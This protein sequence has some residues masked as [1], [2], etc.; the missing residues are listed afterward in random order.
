M[1]VSVVSSISTCSSTHTELQVVPAH[2]LQTHREREREIKRVILNS[3]ISYRLFH[4]VSDICMIN[5]IKRLVL[6]PKVLK[7]GV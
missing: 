4:C 7:L 6:K 1:S 2:L 5:N 3:S